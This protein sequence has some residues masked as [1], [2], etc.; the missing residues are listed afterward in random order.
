MNND[1]QMEVM[2]VALDQSG[3]ASERR[4]AFVDK[5]RDLYLTQ[6]RVYGSARKTVKLSESPAGKEAD[7]CFVESNSFAH[8]T[9]VYDLVYTPHI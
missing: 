9:I 4:L 2:E 6:V 5:N 1:L 8:I 7:Y 3:P